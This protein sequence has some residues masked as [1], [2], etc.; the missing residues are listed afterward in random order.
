MM[1]ILM[2]AGSFA[3]AI[4]SPAGLR[5]SLNRMIQIPIIMNWTINA[6]TALSK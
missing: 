1:R 5:I 6:E 3:A 4:A 2:S